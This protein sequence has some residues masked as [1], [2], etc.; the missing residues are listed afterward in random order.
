MTMTTEHSFEAP[1]D[2]RDDG[3]REEE[4]A[5]ELPLITSLVWNELDDVGR[6]VHEVL[7]G[8]VV[9]QLET[10]FLLSEFR[11]FADLVFRLQGIEDCRTHQKICERTHN[12][13]QSSNVLLFHI[14]QLNA[15]RHRPLT[16]SPLRPGDPPDLGSL[17]RP[18]CY[19]TG[20][21]DAE[22]PWQPGCDVVKVI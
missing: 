13:R 6:D 19:V 18:G 5:S 7:V 1:T 9:E 12:Q 20:R 16:R 3:C 4:G 10:G 17:K 14:Q 8:D 22:S 15:E 11:S 21:Q 2:S